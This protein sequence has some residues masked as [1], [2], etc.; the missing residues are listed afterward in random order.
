M[1]VAR[2]RASTAVTDL[3]AESP[4]GPLDRRH[5]GEL[6]P[7]ERALRRRNRRLLLLVSVPAVIVGAAALIA[8][9]V[10]SSSS[11]SVKPSGVPAG[12]KAV[13]DGYFGYAVPSGWSTNDLFTDAVG[14][15]ETSGSGGWVAEHI[16]VR[17]TPPAPGETPPSS[18]RTLGIVHLE[19]GQPITVPGAQAAYRYSFAATGGPAGVAVNAWQASTGAE[20]W[21][22]VDAPPGVTSQI[23]ASLKA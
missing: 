23:L 5:R 20:L 21:V 13:T 18:L 15:L 8:A 10:A 1:P 12:Y 22:V 19:S 16:G 14:D 2:V 11:P 9:V 7:A 3:P 17:S 6:S 4:R